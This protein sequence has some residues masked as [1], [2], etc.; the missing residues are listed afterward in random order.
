M[1]AA[2]SQKELEGQPTPDRGRPFA[3][4]DDSDPEPLV[5]LG[6][7]TLMPSSSIETRRRRGS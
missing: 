7:S 4:A 6:L 5:G 1:T 2:A 3:D